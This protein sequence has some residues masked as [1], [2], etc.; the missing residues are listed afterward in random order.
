MHEIYSLS[1]VGWK[2]MFD[3]FCPNKH[4][5]D[6]L[7]C[8]KTCWCCKDAGPENITSRLNTGHAGHAGH[9]DCV[10]VKSLLVFPAGSCRSSPVGGRWTPLNWFSNHLP[11]CIVVLKVR[12]CFFLLSS[13][14]LSS[15]SYFVTMMSA[16]GNV[17]QTAD[18]GSGG[19]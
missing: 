3:S 2:W 16:D 18:S 10:P 9:A 13:S 14:L 6:I 7:S 1:C 19:L 8:T 12:F 11:H 5:Y 4:V 17:S 15:N